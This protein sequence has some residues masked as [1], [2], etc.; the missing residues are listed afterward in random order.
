MENTDLLKILISRMTTMVEDIQEVKVTMAK[1]EENLKLHMKR[2]DALEQYVAKLE[3]DVKPIKR[4][5]AMVEGAMK[6]LGIIAT[7][8]TLV[9]GAIKAF[10]LVTGH[11]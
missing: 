6:T 5:M 4:G 11:V 7:I 10:G 9:I 3:E 1:Q 2:S 8:A